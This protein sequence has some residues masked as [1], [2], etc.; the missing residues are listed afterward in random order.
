MY[1]FFL[2]AGEDVYEAVRSLE[3]SIE[4]GIKMFFWDDYSVSWG[5][6]PTEILRRSFNGD[7]RQVNVKTFVEEFRRVYQAESGRV[8]MVFIG[9]DLYID[10]MEYIFSATHMV[11]KVIVI[12]VFR[13]GRGLS[14]SI[15][16]ERSLF[17]ERV[18][19]EVVHELGH[20]IGLQ[21][22]MNDTCVMSFSSDV[23]HLDRKYPF[24]CRSCVEKAEA[25]GFRIGPA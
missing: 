1:R 25:M 15:D 4:A 9:Q 23:S 17:G 6:L 3:G 7:R 21:H 14:L 24:L 19:K 8:D 16:E 22:C 5:R 10:G 18:F 13:L 12:S 11:S 20:L 2:W